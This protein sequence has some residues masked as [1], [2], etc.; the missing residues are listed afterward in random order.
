MA[1]SEALGRPGRRHKRAQTQQLTCQISFDQHLK[2]TLYTLKHLQVQG[3]QRAKPLP[4][5][6]PI[7][8]R[9]LTRASHSSHSRISLTHDSIGSQHRTRQHRTS[10][11]AFY[12]IFGG[13]FLLFL[14]FSNE[15][16][17]RGKQNLEKKWCQ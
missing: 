3:T 16:L 17:K 10:H 4:G 2:N 11:T 12:Y 5:K 15:S 9:H 7:T 1:G 6:Q 13:T 8:S 14:V